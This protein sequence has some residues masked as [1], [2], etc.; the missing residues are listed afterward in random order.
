MSLWLRNPA[1]LMPGWKCGLCSH[2]G[3]QASTTSGNSSRTAQQAT[4]EISS[5][6]NPH[7]VN[8]G[9]H[10]R[11]FIVPLAVLAGKGL[12]TPYVPIVARLW[13]ET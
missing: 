7:M 12:G 5:Q 13:G 4:R 11:M 6:R 3:E 8:P 2:A 10:G 9:V 1:A